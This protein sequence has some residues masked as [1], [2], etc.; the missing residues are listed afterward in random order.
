MVSD[1]RPIPHGALDVWQLCVPM[2]SRHR[3]ALPAAIRQ[4]LL[5]RR[6]PNAQ[7]M[8]PAADG[9]CRTVCRLVGGDKCGRSRFCG[10]LCPDLVLA[11]E[12]AQD[13]D[14]GGLCLPL[15]RLGHAGTC[16][17]RDRPSGTAAQV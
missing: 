3:P 11:T 2:D 17:W 7:Q 6:R 16:S 13:V 10:L 9:F 5:D 4:G 12:A 15:H 1:T 8:E 14:G